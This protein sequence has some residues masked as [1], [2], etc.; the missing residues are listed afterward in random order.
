MTTGKAPPRY[1]GETRDRFD[2]SSTER[3]EITVSLHIL[4]QQ[5]LRF[6]EKLR[7]PKLRESVEDDAMFH[8]A[9]AFLLSPSP[10]ERKNARVLVARL[11]EVRDNRY[12]RDYGQAGAAVAQQPELGAQPDQARSA[13]G[14]LC[15]RVYILRALGEEARPCVLPAGHTASPGAS[16]NYCRTARGSSWI[17]DAGEDPANPRQPSAEHSYRRRLHHAD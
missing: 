15:G 10:V 5:D 9:L 13:G 7:D 4:A 17:F 14:R 16:E 11:V 6:A 8:E 3:S 12:A 1:R 2:L